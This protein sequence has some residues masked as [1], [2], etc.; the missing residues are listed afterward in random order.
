MAHFKI[1]T[2]QLKAAGNF[3]VNIH[4]GDATRY[5][6]NHSLTTLFC[7]MSDGFTTELRTRENQPNPVDYAWLSL[8]PACIVN[9][10]TYPDYHAQKAKEDAARLKVNVGDTLEI[11]GIHVIYTI[12]A[13]RTMEGDAYQLDAAPMEG[14]QMI[15][16]EDGWSF[17]MVAVPA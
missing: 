10:E 5:R 9:R 14:Y 3:G 1:T 6:N 16:Q 2:A 15:R 4:I 12:R 7:Y 11:E 8:G 13:P 17:K